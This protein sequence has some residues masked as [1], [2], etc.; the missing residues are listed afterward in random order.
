[1]LIALLELG[2]GVLNALVRFAGDASAVIAVVLIVIGLA[3]LRVICI[4]IPALTSSA[5]L[6]RL[7]FGSYLLG[8]PFATVDVPR[9]CTSVGAGK[10]VGCICRRSVDERRAHAHVRTGAR[11]SDRDLRYRS[12]DPG[13][14][15]A[16]AQVRSWV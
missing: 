8:L 5:S 12:R 10:E 11:R 1:M 2:S 13:A 4:V 15:A 14:Y 9:P 6:D 3:L 7:F 16:N